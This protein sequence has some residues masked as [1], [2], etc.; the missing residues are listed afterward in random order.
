MPTPLTRTALLLAA[1]TAAAALGAVAPATAAVNPC[2]GTVCS[3]AV[4]PGT[5]EI[6]VTV[7]SKTAAADTGLDVEAH[8]IVLAPV[9]TSAGQLTQRSVTVNVRTPESMPDGQE[10]KGTAGLQVY[11]TGKAPALASIQVT[12]RPHT[13]QQFVISDSTAADWLHG[14]KHGWAQ[15]LPQYFREGIS[16]ANYADSGS[17]T[18][19]WLANSRL[20]ATVRQFIQPGDEVLIQLAHNDKTTPE[21]TYRANLGKLVAGVRAR[22]GMPV[23][24]TPPVR[25]F[26]NSDGTLTP[27]GLIV[28][29]LGV[30][31][32]AVM[33]QVA[34]SER[35]PLLDLTADS[36]ALL[37]K[38]GPTGSWPLYLG[39]QV[40][41]TDSSHFTPYGATVMSGLVVK[42]LTAAH[43]PAAAFIRG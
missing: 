28:N 42:E 27:T 15:E 11:L 18:V 1:G 3:F 9:A 35:V 30:N 34:A 4:P 32:P 13:P 29:N 22:G 41:P 37:E 19:S 16:V 2:T 17:S 14:P 25:H 39:T 21:T 36:A 8:R 10:G 26:F 33:R 6:T 20:F 5:Y 43:L 7:G 24:V 31:L 23:L 38:L 12:A 40:T